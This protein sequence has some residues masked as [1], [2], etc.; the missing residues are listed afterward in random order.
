MGEEVSGHMSVYVVLS[1]SRVYDQGFDSY[2]FPL[3]RRDSIYF[4]RALP[5]F[6]DGSTVEL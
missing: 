4:P 5:L 2:T 3:V 6:D 1:L